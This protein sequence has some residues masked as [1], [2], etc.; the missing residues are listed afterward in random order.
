MSI[1]V[2]S[3]QCSPLTSKLS[4]LRP[5]HL[6]FHTKATT[7][8]GLPINEHHPLSP[9]YASTK[10][11]GQMILCEAYQGCTVLQKA[12]DTRAERA[13]WMSLV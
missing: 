4:K 5:Q 1:A 7:G 9:A 8:N 11:S 13:L 10:W 12:A 2:N 3:L 6:T